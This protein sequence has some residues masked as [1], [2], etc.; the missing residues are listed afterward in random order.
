VPSTLPDGDPAPVDGSLP[1]AAVAE[2]GAVD[3]GFYVHVPF[4]R[5]RCGYCDFNTYTP[6]ELR[7]PTGVPPATDATVRGWAD[8]VRA[9]VAMARRVLGDRDVPVSTVFFGGGTP[10]ML[11]PQELAGVLRCIRDAFGLAENAEV[12]TEA[13][14]DSVDAGSLTELRANGIG[15]ISFGM[16]SAVP[17]VLATLDRTHDA[18]RL[19]D[20]VAAARGAGFDEISL[21]LIYGTPG[22][23]LDDWRKS[24]DAAL[25]LEPD[26]LSA[27]ALIV[28]P[29]TAL[30]RRVDRGEVPAP[31]DD[32]QADKYELAD[33]ALSEA[34]YAWYELSNWARGAAHRCR[35]NLLYWTGG[36]WWGA[37]PG[38]HSHVRGV[39]WWNVKHPAA[40][41]DRLGRDESPAQAREVLDDE[42]RRVERVLLESRLA[43]GLPCAVLEPRA[44]AE[45]PALAAE[46]MVRLEPDAA[47]PE[48]LVLTRR[49]RL[50]ADLVVQRLLP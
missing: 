37:G 4:C 35:H 13:N 9:E 22:E 31:V 26:H 50:L 12:T 6:A 5:V 1:D 34:G 3:F 24:L 16:Q 39:R 30:G 11:P 33:D 48:R 45:L 23:S 32:D 7:P 19:P 42:T 49:G 28:E 15:R 17:H 40:Y 10:T 25:S 2:W 43:A 18:A 41:A 14:P 29:G 36:D 8:S 21:D 44:R 20:V 27:Y 38:A 46:G 47:T